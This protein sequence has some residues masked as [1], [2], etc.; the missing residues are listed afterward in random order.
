LKIKTSA[1]KFKL[2]TKIENMSSDCCLT[3]SDKFFRLY[4]G[5]KKVTFLMR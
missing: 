3:H 2:R 5:E 1:D 4:H